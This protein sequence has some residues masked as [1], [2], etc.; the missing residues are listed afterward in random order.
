MKTNVI[1]LSDYCTG[2]PRKKMSMRKAAEDNM[3]YNRIY[4]VV[5]KV[6]EAFCSLLLTA[7]VIV[8]AVFLTAFV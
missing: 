5:T 6:T 1:Y 2:A 7:S 4:G 3:R 8:G